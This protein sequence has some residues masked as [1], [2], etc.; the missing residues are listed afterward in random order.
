MSDFKK[1]IVD[2]IGV[3]GNYSNHPNDSGGPTMYGITEAVAR[4][5]GYS[6]DMRYMPLHIAIDI[7]KRRYW[8][9]LKLDSILDISPSLVPEI[10]DTGINQGV[11]RAGEYLQVSLNALNR[12]E[13]DYP[14]IKVDGDIGNITLHTLKKYIDKR[15]CTGEVVMLRCLNGL[16]CAF[17]INLTKRREKDEDFLFGWVLN[18]VTI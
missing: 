13:K 17:Y 4:S 6:G 1:H 10:L 16:Q 9:A 2:I 5:Y 14:D 7:Y 18:R 12:Q 3:E 15:G 8:D 11:G